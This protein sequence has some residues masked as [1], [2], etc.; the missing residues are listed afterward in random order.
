MGA[1]DSMK[2]IY[3]LMGKPGKSGSFDLRTPEISPLHADLHSLPPTL[4]QVGDAEVML[5]DAVDFGKKSCT[6]G[7]PVEVVV[8]PRMWHCF[9]RFSEGCG[10]GV[11]LQE[12]IDAF[13]QQAAF[14]QDCSR[15]PD[16]QSKSTNPLQIRIQQH[17]ERDL[18]KG[19]EAH[20]RTIVGQPRRPLQ[21][22]AKAARAASDHWH[23]GV[24][25]MAAQRDYFAKI[26]LL[27]QELEAAGESDFDGLLK[28]ALA[29]MYGKGSLPS[30]STE[31]SAEEAEALD[32][33]WKHRFGGVGHYK[34][35]AHE[36]DLRKAAELRCDVLK[37]L[38]DYQEAA[39]VHEGVSARGVYARA[40]DKL[41][42]EIDIAGEV[43]FDGLLRQA[44]RVLEK[45]TVGVPALKTTDV[46]PEIVPSRLSRSLQPSSK[47]PRRRWR[48]KEQSSRSYV[49]GAE[50]QDVALGA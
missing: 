48:A 37:A 50:A 8:Y 38:S 16:L 30:D 41:R 25:S 11:P 22:A 19:W 49:H 4:I 32:R 20:L 46:E 43:D 23:S 47:K 17:L 13:K 26:E 36:R 2:E 39:S 9:H 21:M 29:C 42:A 45:A 34:G 44:V 40:V 28:E 24:V 18:V 27:L 3:E 12:G 7:S 6:A 5:S 35:R 1:A 14:F 33:I 10:I 31:L 15:K